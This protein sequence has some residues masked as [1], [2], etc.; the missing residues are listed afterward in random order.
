MQH[1]SA[2]PAP[3]LQTTPLHALHVEL[4]GR[5]VDFAGWELPIQYEGVV[6]EHNWCRTSAGL[7]DVSHMGVVELHGPNV[8]AAL[9]RLTPAGLV[10]LKPGKIRYA[11]FTNDTGGV[12]D[13]LMVTNVGDHLVIVVNAARRLVDLPH[14]YENLPAEGPDK[15]TIVER[16]DVALLALQGPKAVETFARLPRTDSGNSVEEMAF[17]E[18]RTILVTLAG[19][20]DP[21]EL[22]VSR[23]GYTGE[24]GLEITVPGNAAEALARWL[25]A[26]D[27]IKPAGLGA[28]DTLRLEASLCLYGNDLSETISPVEADLRWTMPKRRREAKDFPGADIIMNQYENGP[29]RIRVGLRAE[30]RRPVRDHTSLKTLDGEAAGEVSSGGYGPTVEHPVAMGYVPPSLA[31]VGTKLIADVRG[32]DVTMTVVDLPFVA[33]NYRR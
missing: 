16:D 6:A 9:E 11:L 31:T 30:G 29:D 23:S 28:R 14:L 3:A 12:I 22:S 17:M 1:D 18:A 25:L 19:H 7:F 2:S 4:G 32:S 26:Q 20:D 24:D 13:D 10:T 5:M 15:I 8:A 27:E 33:H 21:V